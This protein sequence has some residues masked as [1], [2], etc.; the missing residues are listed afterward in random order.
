MKIFRKKATNNQHR[1][2][3]TVFKALTTLFPQN[4][5]FLLI[6]QL[7]MLLNSLSQLAEVLGL[8]N[9][10]SR[11][12]SKYLMLSQWHLYGVSW[13]NK[14]YFSVRLTFGCKSSPSIFNTLSEALFGFLSNHTRLNPHANIFPFYQNLSI[15]SQGRSFISMDFLKSVDKLNDFVAL[16]E[17]CR[18]DLHFCNF[19][20]GQ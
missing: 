4:H 12:H 8:A 16:D 5:S 15:P 9:Q 13:C 7:T 11:M 17:E 10:I 1:I 14:V 2:P 6:H 19:N 20:P 3:P 18:S